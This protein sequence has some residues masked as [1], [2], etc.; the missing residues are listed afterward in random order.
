MQVKGNIVIMEKILDKLII[1]I[2]C[3]IF[4]IGSGLDIYTVVP[5]VIAVAVTSFNVAF[6]T[7]VLHIGTYVLYLIACCFY[8]DLIHFIPL[9]CYDLFFEPYRYVSAAGLIVLYLNFEQLKLIN[10]VWLI[11]LLL[12]TYLLKMRTSALLTTRYD[13]YLIRD[14]LKQQSDMLKKRNRELMEKQDYEIT[15]ATLNERNRIAREIHD[16]V[17][18]LLSSSLLQIG[19]LLAISQDEQQK[20]YLN[21]IKETLSEGMDSIRSSI[22][23]IHEESMDLE[24]KLNELIDN[25]SF[26]EV[27]LNYKIT[28][29]FSMKAKY[30]LMFIV[31]EALSNVMK[32]SDAT[33]VEITFAELPAFYRIIIEDNGQIFKQK[34]NKEKGMGLSGMCDRING[35]EGNINISANNGYR[36]FIT[37]PKEAGKIV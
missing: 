5:V 35:L 31:K 13:S 16:T 37:L 25:F 20:E 11:A 12:I 8:H 26:C 17:G 22:H 36:I 6:D 32:H 27:K 10:I 33:H 18:H 3:T 15:N 28:Q 21:R 29:D 7:T 34:D 9:M 23:N 19:A 1:F 14:E 2:S 4:L 30:S 24:A